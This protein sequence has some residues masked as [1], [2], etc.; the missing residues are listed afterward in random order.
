MLL[1][2][3]MFCTAQ[4]LYNVDYVVNIVH[5]IYILLLYNNYNYID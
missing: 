2:Q 1:L 5:I 3:C 4:Y